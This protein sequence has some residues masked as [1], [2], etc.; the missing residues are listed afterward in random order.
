MT[1]GRRRGRP[2]G[3][4]GDSREAI[5]TAARARFAALGY[6]GTTLRAIAADADVDV[7]LIAH[8]FTSK[9]NL[10]A[11]SMS[12]PVDIHTVLG[13]VIPGPLDELAERMLRAFLTTWDDHREAFAALLRSVTDG[14]LEHPPA[15]DLIREVPVAALRRT[16][17][18]PD[19]DLRADLAAAVISGLALQR[20]VVRLD[21]LTDA[22][23]DDVVARYAPA[24]DA[25]L[26]P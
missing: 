6:R 7:S 9:E 1:A 4:G 11:A 19:A 23:I 21:P 14:S 25:V 17:P 16:L 13:S 2:T 10:L 8:Y 18:G 26:N 15:L 12:L 22:P 20:Y 3:G 5:L 24:L